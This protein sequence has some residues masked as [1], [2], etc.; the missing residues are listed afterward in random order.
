MQI[1]FDKVADAIYVKLKRGKAHKTIVRGDTF[2]IDLDKK[3]SV[4]G[5]EVLNYSKT[6]PKEEKRTYVSIGQQR[7]LLP[8]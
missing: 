6:Q 4:L 8:A 1:K 5:F 3:G 2:L 7:F